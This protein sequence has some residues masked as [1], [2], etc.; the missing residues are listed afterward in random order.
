[1]ATIEQIQKSQEQIAAQLEGQLPAIVA[2]TAPE[3][4]QV[5]TAPH[6]L[7]PM[8]Q[9]ALSFLRRMYA[10]AHLRA[11]LRDLAGK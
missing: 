9:A 1:M 7:P 5:A 4:P 10:N 2:G 6:Q 3:S 11:V 8:S